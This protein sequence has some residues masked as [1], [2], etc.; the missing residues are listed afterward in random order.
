MTKLSLI[1]LPLPKVD[2]DGELPDLDDE[3]P[4]TSSVVREFKQQ[5]AKNSQKPSTPEPTPPPPQQRPLLLPPTPPTTQ[6]PGL[7]VFPVKV[8]A[9]DI[10]DVELNVCFPFIDSSYPSHDKLSTFISYVY[11]N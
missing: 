10:D 7:V 4:S 3:E 1:K 9:F 6:F 5:R 2:D 11:H 8:E